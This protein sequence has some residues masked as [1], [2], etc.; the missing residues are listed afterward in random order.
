[1]LLK[2]KIYLFVFSLFFSFLI[3]IPNIGTES[4]NPDAVNWHYRCQQFANGIKFF[5]LEK[6]YPHY[7]PGVT[8]CWVMFFPTEVYKQFSNQKNY[9]NENYLDFNVVNTIFLVLFIS[10]LLSIL[11]VQI[12]GLKGLIFILLLNLEP[13]FFSNSKLIHL[14]TLHSL[15]LFQSVIILWS[16]FFEPNKIFKIFKFS[17]KIPKL[18]LS[19]FFLGLAFLT[20][21]V[22]LVFLPVMLAFLTIKEKGNF[23]EG[24]KKLSVF[25]ITFLATVFILFPALWIDPIGNLTRIIREADRVGVRTGHSQI[26]FERFY[27]EDDNPGIAF[28]IFTLIVKF[29]PLF[30]YCIIV[31]LFEF[32]KSIK[33]GEFKVLENRGIFFLTVYSFYIFAIAYSDKKVDRYLLL[34]IPVVFYLFTFIFHKYSKYVIGFLILNVISVVYFHPFQFLYY[35]PIL[36]N[37]ENAEKIIAQK[38]FGMGIVELR[39]YIVKNFG[40]VSVGMYDIKPLEALYPNSKVFDIRESSKSKVDIVIL[41]KDESLPENYEGNFA[42]KDIFYLKDLPVYQIY[43]KN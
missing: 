17:F 39:D 33:N 27:G 34:L 25:F 15:L 23:H 14:D 18:A 24:F 40:D 26:F 5:Q 30:L 12:G 1:M 35:S 19:G 11:A 4:I 28:Y 42:L 32:I 8:L 37:F 41:T 38:S 2:N 22:T 43:V 29:S 21:S 9:N 36:G 20:K 7:H 3:R 6:T 16:Y 13:F 31:L 10:F